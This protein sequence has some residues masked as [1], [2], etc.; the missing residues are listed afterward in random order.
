MMDQPRTKIIVHAKRR[1]RGHGGW[2]KNN[3][4]LKERFVQIPVSIDPVSLAGR[5]LDVREQ[6]ADEWSSDLD[7]VAEANGAVMKSYF[8]GVRSDREWDGGLG[9]DTSTSPLPSSSAVAGGRA[10]E[11]AEFLLPG[12]SSPFRRGNFDLLYNLCTQAAIHRLLREDRANGREQDVAYLWLRD[13]YTERAAEYFDGDQPYGRADDF[14]DE[15]LRTSP[16]MR[17]AE[18]GRKTGLSDPVGT[19]ERI[20]RR[21]GEVAEECMRRVQEEHNVHVRRLMLSKQVE[22]W[23]GSTEAPVATTRSGRDD[24]LGAFE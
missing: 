4:Y 7:V 19:A 13:F 8:E 9:S 18:D 1:G 3:P 21:R 11:R 15:M 2:S 16:S 23:A 22:S 24:E 6:I 14:L 10:F 17:T 12:A 20:L 5:I